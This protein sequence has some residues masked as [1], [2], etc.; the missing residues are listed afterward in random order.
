MC[1]LANLHGSWD[2]DVKT[3]GQIVRG[4]ADVREIRNN[5]IP[6]WFD[7]LDPQKIN[8]VLAMYGRGYTL[9][10]PS[11]N[12]L[13]CHF[14]GASKPAECTK[15]EGVMSLTEIKRRATELNIKPKYLN[16]YFT[17]LGKKIQGKVEQRVI[18]VCEW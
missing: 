4:Q 11:C 1:L 8:I 5:T 10:D 13:G 16:K 18:V 14:I 12:S 6:L 17:E 15:S 3:L 7:G 2:S 9:A